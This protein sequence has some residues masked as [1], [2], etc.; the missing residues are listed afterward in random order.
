[1]HNY[2]LPLL[3]FKTKITDICN[4]PHFAPL[5]INNNV[6]NL[7]MKDIGC[8]NSNHLPLLAQNFNELRKENKLTVD[9]LST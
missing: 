2:L 8:Y 1:M 9:E 4:L 3:H 5:A 7:P 6:I